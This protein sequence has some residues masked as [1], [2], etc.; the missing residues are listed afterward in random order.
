LLAKLLESDN[1]ELLVPVVG[2]LQEC[3]NSA[4]YR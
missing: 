4:V 3:A 2:V 1:V